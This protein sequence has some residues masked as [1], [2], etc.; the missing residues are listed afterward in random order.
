LLLGAVGGAMA[1]ATGSTLC[2]CLFS[3]L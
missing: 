1:V 3:N 2:I